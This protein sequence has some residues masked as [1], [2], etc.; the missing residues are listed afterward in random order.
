MFL[1]GVQTNLGQLLM[2]LCIL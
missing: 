2:L 1:G